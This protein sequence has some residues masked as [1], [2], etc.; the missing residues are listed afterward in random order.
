MSDRK[1]ELPAHLRLEGLF[2]KRNK[3]AT[4]NFVA[5]LVKVG[6]ELGYSVD[7]GDRCFIHPDDVPAT[8]DLDAS[9]PVIVST[10]PAIV[11]GRLLWLKAHTI[12]ER[13]MEPP[14]ITQVSSEVH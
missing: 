12:S 4:R 13:L 2:E 6:A 14:V 3:V 9:H 5:H 7:R 1:L 8:V 10:A 11:R